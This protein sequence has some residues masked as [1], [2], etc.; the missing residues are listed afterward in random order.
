MLM[1][2]KEERSVVNFKERKVRWLGLE[3]NEVVVCGICLLKM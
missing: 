1:G 3:K 2:R